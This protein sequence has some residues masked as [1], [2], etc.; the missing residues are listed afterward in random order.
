[1]EDIFWGNLYKHNEEQ[2][3][4]LPSKYKPVAEYFSAD[5]FIFPNIEESGQEINLLIDAIDKHNKSKNQV[6]LELDKDAFAYYRKFAQDIGIKSKDAA[7]TI[8]FIKSNIS[9]LTLDL[10]RYWNRA[11]PYQYGYLLDLPIYPHKTKSGGTTP[12]Y[13]SG[14]SLQ[15]IAFNKI[16]SK[17]YPNKSAA[18]EQ[19]ENEVHQSRIA[20]GV[21]FASDIN[22]S[23]QIGEYITINNLWM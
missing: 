3:N 11:R 22:F 14:H 1:M 18:L 8:E 7:D 21:H 20:L 15:A 10:K 12:C 13:P 16:L 2:A 9:P 4:N 6:Y 5:E 19:L 17:K 23:I